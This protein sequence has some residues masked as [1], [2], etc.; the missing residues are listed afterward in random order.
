MIESNTINILET[1]AYKLAK[2]RAAK[3][4]R[5]SNIS[6]AREDSAR[7]IQGSMSRDAFFDKYGYLP[8]IT[9]QGGA[10]AWKRDKRNA[11]IEKEMAARDNALATEEM[12]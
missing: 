2:A 1:P 5:E 9:L 4:N 8:K 6:K 3:Y 7:V 12:E 10:K 11:A